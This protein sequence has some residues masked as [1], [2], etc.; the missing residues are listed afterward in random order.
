MIGTLAVIA[1]F[2]AFLF[3]AVRIARQCSNQVYRLIAVGITTWIM[4]EAIINIASV[5]GWW[6]VT[7]VPLPFFS[8][9]GTALITE[10][11]AVGVLYNIAHD[12]TR[13]ED[14]TI[15]RALARSRRA[16]CARGRTLDQVR[17][18]VRDR[19]RARA[20]APREFRAVPPIAATRRVPQPPRGDPRPKS[21]A[22][23]EV[24]MGRPVV[25]TGGGTGGHVFPMQR[26]RGGAASKRVCRHRTCA[27]WAAAGAKRPRCCAARS[28]LTLLPGRGV[29]RSLAPA[30]PAR[31]PG[32]DR[33]TPGGA[34]ERAVAP[35]ALAALGG[36]LGRRLR[37]L[38]HG[39]GGAVCAHPAR[40]RRL[41]RRARR[42]PP[43]ARA[44][45]HDAVLRVRRRRLQRGRH[46]RSRAALHRGTGSFAPRA[47]GGVRPSGATRR[48][49][50]DGRRRGHGIA[51]ALVGST[52]PRAS[53]PRSGVSAP[54]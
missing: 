7:G 16:P 5:V 36:G 31:Q 45:R 15:P 8:Y 22:H 4:V 28:P 27:S 37:L 39:R 34:G 30:R 50:A 21:P 38:R 47:S 14:F 33:R 23:R 41:R 12:R 29:R 25:I 44:I 48:P 3:V 10:L 32:G 43:T 26:D 9:G 6:A 13:T 54:T 42:R 2:I 24:L 1:L 35:V 11:A 46:R 17:D 40:S 19:A 53:S 18:Q 51:R 52:R 49:R 20:P